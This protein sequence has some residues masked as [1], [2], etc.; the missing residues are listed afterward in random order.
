MIKV[1]TLFVHLLVWRIKHSSLISQEKTCF[2][3]MKD[4]ANR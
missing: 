1:K 3:E 4:I 2:P